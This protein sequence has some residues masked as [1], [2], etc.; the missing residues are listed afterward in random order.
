MASVGGVKLPEVRYWDALSSL[1]RNLLNN[2]N[3]R[4][5]ALALLPSRNPTNGCCVVLHDGKRARFL[6]T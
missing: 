1:A 3:D 6:L 4:G 5:R 2:V